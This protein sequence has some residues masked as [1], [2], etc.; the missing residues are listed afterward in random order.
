MDGAE[1]T[2]AIEAC[3]A[4]YLGSLPAGSAAPARYAE[5]SAFGALGEDALA[6]ELA[7]LIEGNVKTATSTLLRWYE[8]GGHSLERLGDCW[9]VLDSTG[10]PRCV[11][12]VTEV[13]VIPLGEVDAAFAADYG[14]GARTLAW[15]RTHLGAY[16][17]EHAATAG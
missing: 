14:E 3:W 8:E 7:A 12:E 15:R 10:R 13:R 9:V 4:A 11:V 17:A 1:Q 2:D 16:Y 5:A 6:D